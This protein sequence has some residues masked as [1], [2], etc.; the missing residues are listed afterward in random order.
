MIAD[1]ARAGRQGPFTR[2]LR[3]IGGYVATHPGTFAIA[4][5]SAGVYAAAT[6]AS[7]VVLGR[8]T[9]LVLTP[10]FHGHVSSRRALVG[11]LAVVGVAVV[12]A[13]GIVFRRYFAGM[14]AERMARTLREMVVDRYRDLPLAYHRA[15]PAG[16]MMAHAEAD[17]VA[18]TQVMHPIPYSSAVIMLVLFATISLVLTDPFMALIGCAVMPLLAVMNRFYGGRVEPAVSQVQEQIG[19]VS[20]VA[21]ESVDGAMVVKTLGREA[22]EVSRMREQ[23][24]HLRALRMRVGYIRANFEPAFDT[25]PVIGNILLLAVGSWRVSTGSIT[26]GTL[27]QFL[28][29][30]QLLAFPIRLLGFVL[31][32][33]PLAVVGRERLNDVFTDESPSRP[34]LGGTRPLPGGALTVQVHGLEFGYENAPV[35][36]DVSFDLGAGET[37]ALVGPTGCGKSTLLEL[38]V[39]L[40]RPLRGHIV[41]G[42]VELAEVDAA[43]LR[44][45][46]AIVFQDSFL[47]GSTVRD[48]ISLGAEVSLEEV[49]RA[50][51]L[52]QADGFITAI[53]GGYDA[54][55]G[56][57]GASLSGGQ[58]QRIALARAL[59]RQPSLLLLDDAT[60]AVD[61]RVEAAILAGLRE[62]LSCT[63]LVVAHRT[64]TIAL[65]DRVVVM[66]SGRV[67]ALG[68]QDEVAA[69]PTYQAIITAYQVARA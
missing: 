15:R 54:V 11:A 26:P 40:E 22:A 23:A 67:V 65:A 14:T 24:D 58:R 19:V 16:E 25:L 6:V 48:N 44:A 35:L 61:P 55:V 38:L 2:G 20:S 10:A 32:D 45:A 43:Q 31:V 18:A 30:F 68:T 13:I 1:A 34:D 37:V 17:V 36:R 7:A 51:R 59:L 57:R 46:V 47:F 9:D 49:V 28:S 64:S 42:G 29:L 33:I 21:H 66:D 53:D 3:I 50:A 12:R 8:V 27:V 62:Q 56:E 69:N 52:A 63:L 39:G 60:S 41:L 4:V 5:G